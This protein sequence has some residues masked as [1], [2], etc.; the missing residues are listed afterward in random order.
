M[1]TTQERIIKE[2]ISA[3]LNKNYEEISVLNICSILNIKRQT[4]YYH[5]SN[6]FD[7]LEAYFL[8]ENI[9]INLRDENIDFY[10]PLNLYINNNY[11]ILDK[12]IKIDGNEIVCGFFQRYFFKVFTKIFDLNYPENININREVN[13]IMCNLYAKEIV[14]KLERMS[15]NNDKEFDSKITL[16]KFNGVE[17]LLRNNL[18]L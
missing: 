17:N 1:L 13:R 6:L 8:N 7:V 2:V 18:N 15:F 10:T 5:F 3:L 4:F 16:A 12:I 9:D 11:E 14:T